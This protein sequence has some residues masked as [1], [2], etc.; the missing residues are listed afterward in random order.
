MDLE[1]PTLENVA[2]DVDKP[3]V[4]PKPKIQKKDWFKDSSKTKVLDPEWNTIKVIDD[5]PEQPWFNQ[6]LQ[7]VKPPLTFDDLMGTPIDFSAFAMNHLQIDNIIRE[8]FVGP[9]FN[10]LKGHLRSVDMSKPL[11]LQ[12]KEGRQV[13]P[14]EVFF[15][16]DL[17]YI[18]AGNKER[19]YSSSI[20]KAPAA[21]YTMKGIE[22]MIPNLW[23]LVVEKKEGYGYLNEIVVRRADQNM[24]KFKEGDF[25]DLHL[26]DIEDMLLL[27]AQNKLFNQDGD[28]I[29]D[30]VTTLKM[31]TRGIILPN[32]IEDVQLGV[33]YEDKKKQKR[34]M[35]V[36]E[37][38]KFS[39]GTL[40]SVHK[41]LLHRFKNFRL[42]Y[43]PKSDM[44]LREWTD[45]DKRRTRIMLK[46]IDDLLLKRR[47]LRSLEVL[48]GGRKIEMDK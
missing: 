1:E 47:I 33:I 6:M 9:L 37:L 2:N 7:A 8:V 24:Y 15:N 32:R 14:I 5:T 12:D 17:E 19:T 38:Y 13:I 18:T 22:D 29:V 42:G 31:F 3:H 44:P 28:V 35:Q 20:M 27:V 11:H 45:K 26:N 30:F 34:L 4:D 16:N 43:N 40:Q 21:R 41:I 23:S 36:D 48:V 39:D 10:L 25:P 46:K